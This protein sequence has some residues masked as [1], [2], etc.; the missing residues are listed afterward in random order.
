[1]SWDGSYTTVTR[2]R[3]KD[4][5]RWQEDGDTRSGRAAYLEDIV[6][7]VAGVEPLEREVC[8]ACQTAESQKGLVRKGKLSRTGENRVRTTSQVTSYTARPD[9]I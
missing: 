9:H 1:V 2:Q 8:Y 7:Q 5:A 6:M 3:T 4:L